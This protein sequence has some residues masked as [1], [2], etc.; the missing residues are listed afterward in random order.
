ML[1]TKAEDVYVDNIDRLTQ[2]QK[3]TLARKIYNLKE[4]F[5]SLPNC[6]RSSNSKCENLNEEDLKKVAQEL[7]EKKYLI[8]LDDIW[9]TKVWDEFKGAFQ[10]DQKDYEISVKEVIQLWIAEGFIQ[11]ENPNA[12]EELED[13][14]DRYLDDLVDRS[15]VQVAK[16]RSDGGVKTCQIHD[17]H[18]R[19]YI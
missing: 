5:L 3:H 2:K 4:L 17:L 15:L 8:V 6:L 1:P 19:E 14:G 10:D 16:R 13:V 12:S 7:K 18:I 11:I 9:E